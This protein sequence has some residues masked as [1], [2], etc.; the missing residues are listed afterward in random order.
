MSELT[1]RMCWKMVSK[2]INLQL[3]IGVAVFQK[4]LDN[5]CYDARPKDALPPMCP[6]W[7]NANAAW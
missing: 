7:D 4:P 1:P 2:V 5:E 6:E 3:G